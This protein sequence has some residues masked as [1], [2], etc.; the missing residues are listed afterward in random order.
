MDTL[1]I[2]SRDPIAPMS[3]V[4]IFVAGPDVWRAVP[5]APD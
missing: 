2:C 5:D 1:S 4:K 3:G